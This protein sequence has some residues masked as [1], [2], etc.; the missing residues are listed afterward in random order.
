MAMINL[1]EDELREQRKY[2]SDEYRKMQDADQLARTV[3]EIA[4]ENDGI[5]R[6]VQLEGESSF[7]EW[8]NED[9]LVPAYSSRRLRIRMLEERIAT[10]TAPP[11]AP[12]QMGERHLERVARAEEADVESKHDAS[13]AHEK[14]DGEKSQQEAED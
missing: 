14:A 1:S 11:P 5:R 8:W 6:C 13:V 7:Y 3:A 10:L 12:P 4:D 2:L 9:A